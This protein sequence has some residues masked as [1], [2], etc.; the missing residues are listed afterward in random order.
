MD[1]RN[2]HGFGGHDWP[3]C[4]DRR[5][6]YALSDT[7]W[8]LWGGFH[9]LFGLFGGFQAQLSGGCAAFVEDQAIKVIGQ[10][11]QSE[12]GLRACQA[13]GADEQPVAVLLMCK[14]VLNPGTDC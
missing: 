8:P 6:S 12:F 5:E 13:N 3:D 4:R 10:V 7:D 1:T 14:D 9:R 11:G 2:N